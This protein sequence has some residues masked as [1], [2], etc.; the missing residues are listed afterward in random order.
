MFSVSAKCSGERIFVKMSVHDLEDLL[1]LT[2]FPEL[3]K[4][5]AKTVRIVWRIIKDGL[6][7]ST[8]TL[9]EDGSLCFATVI[10]SP[11]W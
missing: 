10:S 11:C 2:S 9:D 8:T 4:T 1:G 6:A 7:T 5:G 3:K